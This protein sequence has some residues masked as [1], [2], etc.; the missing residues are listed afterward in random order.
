MLSSVSLLANVRNPPKYC[1]MELQYR[2]ALSV[3]KIACGI[4]IL[5]AWPH[6]GESR[7]A[8]IKLPTP[9]VSIHRGKLLCY[10]G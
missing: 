1:H 5:W 8:I 10:R 7:Q 4:M 6:Q 2:N 9:F 3:S